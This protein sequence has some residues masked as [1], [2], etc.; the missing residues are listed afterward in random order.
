MLFKR[1]KKDKVLEEAIEFIEFQIK[2][3]NHLHNNIDNLNEWNRIY[4]NIL[5]ILKSMRK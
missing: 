4:K 1:K 5:K 3:I 2:T